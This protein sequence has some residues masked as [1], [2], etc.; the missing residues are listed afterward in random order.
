MFNYIKDININL[1][2]LF[3][4]LIYL[5]FL[6][7]VFSPDLN[8]NFLLFCCI[9]TF[10]IFIL[11]NLFYFSQNYKIYIKININKNLILVFFSIFFSN[12]IINYIQLNNSPI[13]DEF[14]YIQYSFIHSISIINLL[15]FSFFNNFEFKNLIWITNILIILITITFLYFLKKLNKHLK[16]FILLLGLILFRLLISYY[17]ENLFPHS[18]FNGIFV[19]LGSFLFGLN[20]LVINISNVFIFCV[21]LT[22]IYKYLDSFI[23]SNLN[24]FLVLIF[25]SSIPINF[26]L[27]GVIDH[28]FI[29]F[30]II[31]LILLYLIDEKEI[32]Q[33][34]ILFLII[35]GS[36]F[37]VT[38]I[39]LLIPFFIKHIIFNNQLVLKNNF[40]KYFTLISASLPFFFLNLFF[41]E[42]TGNIFQIVE[43]IKNKFLFLTIYENVSIIYIFFFILFVLSFD[44]KKILLFYLSFLVL[45]IIYSSVNQ[46]LLS[47]IKYKSEYFVPFSI[48][49]FLIISKIHINKINKNFFSFLIILFTIFNFIKIYTDQTNLKSNE[50]IINNYNTERENP[51][52]YR[53][54]Q[55]DYKDLYNYIKLNNIENQTLNL[56]IT[57][58]VFPEIL[59]GYNYNSVKN[60]SKKYNNYRNYLKLNNIEWTSASTKYFYSNKDFNYLIIGFIFPNKVKVLNDLTK[61]GWSVEKLFF[62]ERF[63]S[64][65]YLMKKNVEKNNLIF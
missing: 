52:F 15:D 26:N 47:L 49:S 54:I 64:K 50:Y 16:I 25:L 10:I 28:S 27:I 43:L 32:N 23:S 19:L 8:K 14:I 38:I 13:S 33:D 65:I 3:F 31:S 61:D 39:F 45:I 11:I 63:D 24:K 1:C 5:F 37:R 55:Y 9:N 21:F 6:F 57:Y 4:T 59:Y 34:Y 46:N 7:G 35:I 29:S 36:L 2:K 42:S 40:Y 56:D 17:G 12:L 44:L 51:F 58:G 60:I 18:P 62:N 53:Q 30:I 41:S 20:N 48:C 22:F